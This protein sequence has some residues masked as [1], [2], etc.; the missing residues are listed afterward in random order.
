M[1]EKKIE[2]KVNE[3]AKSKGFLVYKFTSPNRRAVPDRMYVH[4]S[5]HVSF[6]EFKAEGKLPTPAQVREHAKLRGHGVQ[7]DVVDSIEQGKMVIDF[8]CLLYGTS[9]PPGATFVD[10]PSALKRDALPSTGQAGE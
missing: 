4:P 3:Y 8:L 9:L 10:N 2:E 1:L 5:G 7:V 6:I